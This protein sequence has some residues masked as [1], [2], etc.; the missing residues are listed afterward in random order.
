MDNLCGTIHTSTLDKKSIWAL[1]PLLQA[2]QLAM[3]TED[4]ESVF[5][6]I[7][8]YVYIG[9]YSGKALDLLEAECCIYAHQAQ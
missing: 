4:T 5:Y 7:L 3:H 2:Y 8:Q 6:A 1:M 9:F